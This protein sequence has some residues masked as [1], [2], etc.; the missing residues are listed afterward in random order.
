M[1]KSYI[2]LWHG[3]DKEFVVEFLHEKVP[4]NTDFDFHLPNPILG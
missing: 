3:C 4:G 1:I 2:P